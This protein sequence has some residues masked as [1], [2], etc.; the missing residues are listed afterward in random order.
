M[1]DQDAIRR[2]AQLLSASTHA[3]ALTGAGI[4]TPSG[5]P[6][7]RSPESGLWE[8]YDP[9][10]VASIDAFR[11][12][13]AAFYEWIRPL[14][15][16]AAAAKPNPA[17][18]ALARL[19]QRGILKAVITQNIDDLHV[20]AGS[21][22]VLE[23]HG[24]M[25]TA[26]CIQCRRR[27]NTEPLLKEFLQR[28]TLPTCGT[29]GGALKPDIILFGELLPTAVL[30]EAQFETSACDVML[31]AGSSLEVTPAA[32][33]PFDAHRSGAKLILVNLQR[34]S[35]DHYAEVVIH[36]DVADVLPQIADLC[37]RPTSPEEDTWT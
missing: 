17:H 34:T 25:R 37:E 20:R 36:D 5:V 21:R 24:H 13:P 33:L 16:K 32:Y 6:D 19:E 2:A 10:A 28:G 22:R 12:N 8:K 29:C 15:R 9:M 18:T 27:A 7:F 26:T 35:A 30:V 14:A 11:R 4:S 1:S 3:V 31:V 23:L